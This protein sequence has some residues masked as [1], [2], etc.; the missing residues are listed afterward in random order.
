M[1]DRAYGRKVNVDT[2]EL[3]RL[4]LPMLAPFRSGAVELADRDLLLVRVDARGDDGATV[5][6]WGECAALTGT[7]Y[8]AEDVDSV[9]AVLTR[10]SIASHIERFDPAF[11]MASAVLR[12][13]VLDASL[14]AEGR[15]LTQRLGGE[16]RRVPAG[17]AVGFSDTVDALVDEI[18]AHVDTGY[19]RV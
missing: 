1:L 14:R 3:V 15:S 2:M 18:G 16:R 19:R 7:G 11:P 5:T 13:A 17:V 12:T 9:I 10:G 8:T 6:G 4:R